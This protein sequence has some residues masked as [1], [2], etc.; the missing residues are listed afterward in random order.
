MIK[1]KIE[2]IRFERDGVLIY[3]TKVHSITG[4]AEISIRKSKQMIVYEYA[5]EADF[6]AESDSKECSGSFKVTEINESDFDFHI[7]NISISKDGEIGEKVKFLLRKNLKQ[8]IEK[9]IENLQEEIRQ[10]DFQNKESDQSN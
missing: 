10:I 3:V 4:D 8:E 6:V 9:S 7:P 5:L 2:K 1:S